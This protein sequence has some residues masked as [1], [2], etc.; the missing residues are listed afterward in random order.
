MPWRCAARVA[1]LI[2]FACLTLAQAQSFD[3]STLSP[4]AYQPSAVAYYNVPYFADALATGTEWLAFTDFDFGAPIGLDSP[5][6]DA[7]GLPRSLPSGQ[8]LRAILFGLNV[9]DEF[10]PPGWPARDRLTKGRVV[11]TWKGNADVRL[12]RGTFVPEGSSGPATGALSD[13]R[14][15]YLCRESG[16]STQSLEIHAIASPITELHVWLPTPDNPLTPT[17]ESESASLEGQ[18]FHPLLLQRIGDRNMAFIRFMDWGATN[19][20]PQQDWSDRRLPSHVFRTGLLNR[21]SPGGGADGNRETGVAF[22]HMVMLSNATGR[23]LWINVPHLATDDFITRLAQLIRFGS[24][25]TNPYTSVN[26]APVYPPLRSDLKVFVEYSNEIWSSGPSFPQGDWAQEEA[27]KRNLTKAQFNARRFSDTWRIFQQVFGGTQ[28]LVRVAAVFTGLEAYTRPF[29]QELGT[30]GATLNPPVRPDVLAVTTYFGNAMQDFVREKKYAEGKLFDDPYWTSALFATHR[31]EAFD[32]WTRRILSGDSAQGGGFD[33]TAE[34]GGFPRSLHALPLE[35]LGYALPL[36]AYEGG[37]SLYTDSFDRD[38]TDARGIPTDD[39]V[40]TFIEAMNRD[41]RMREVYDIHLNLAKSKGLW[42]HTPYTDAGRWSKFG[43][44]GHL[45]TLD[46]NPVDSPKY[47][48]LLAHDDEFRSIRSID[49]PRGGT[50]RFATDA[51]LP[52]GIVGSPYAVNI[53][54]ADGEAPRVAKLIGAY[55]DG[56]LGVTVAGDQVRVSGTPSVSRRNYVFA[57]VVDADG[58]PAWKIFTLETFGGR[59][60]LLQSNFRGTSPA[61]ASPWT[62]THVLSPKIHFSGWSVGTSSVTPREGDNAFVFSVAA[63]SSADEPLGQSISGGHYLRITITPTAA[64]DLRNAEIRFS[65]RRIDF[66]APRGYAVGTSIAGF[67]EATMHYV[68]PSVDKGDFGEVEHVLHLPSTAA[69][70]N[71]TAAVELRIYAFGAQFEGHRTSL[72]SFK[73]T[74]ASK[75]RARPVRR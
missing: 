44:W 19:G 72:T 42:T 20:S 71:I 2:L 43:Q 48:L 41:P 40:T 58:D 7:N 14:R 18:L 28:R 62:P 39:F 24:D 4:L 65:T 23:N 15:V 6:F 1:P 49:A 8:K 46:Q 11:V 35:T 9:N 70:N 60:T 64:L 34:G 53:T 55:L 5:I 69:Y 52:A 66:H 16:E 26:A 25:G 73:L 29:L 12:I 47:S 3:P 37:P 67:T 50:P 38:A 61:L 59:G 32:E 21:R 33:T 27:T 75:G 54:T 22:E 74:E 31:N 68:S 63:P 56:G 36:I 10:R 57:R 17:D 30:Y 13:G 45:E 51:L